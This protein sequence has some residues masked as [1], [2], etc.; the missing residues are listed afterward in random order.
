MEY[1]KRGIFVF[2]ILILNLGVVYA[3]CGDGIVDDTETCKTCPQDNP[4]L[5]DQRCVQ[6]KCINKLLPP[7]LIKEDYG[8][9]IIIPTDIG[10]ILNS[11][12]TQPYEFA[13]CLKGRYAEGRY[14]ITKIEFPEISGQSLYAVEHAKCKGFGTIATVHTHL[15]GSCELSKA[16]IFSFGQKDEPLTGIIC[17]KNDFALYSKKGL[18]KRMNYIIRDI[19]DSRLGYFW[20]LFPWVFSILLIVVLLVLAYER[21]RLR[22]LRRK[23][24]ALFMIEKFSST[25]K[26]MVDN[27]LEKGSVLKQDIKSNI[28]EKLMKEKIIEESGNKIYLKHWFKKA[29]RGL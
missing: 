3:F 14:Q 23:D 17:G 26:K 2:I 25:E 19:E 10:E 11:L 27:L 13:A 18:T 12:L 6:G 9:T 1:M 20:I 4:C 15:D 24:L 5:V 8:A 7:I 16:D 29:L 22:N 28:R 21:E